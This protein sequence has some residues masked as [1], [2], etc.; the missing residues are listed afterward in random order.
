MWRRIKIYDK[1]L[2]L[3]TSGSAMTQLG[4]NTNALFRS[5]YLLRK[6][7]EEAK[8]Y[9]LSRIEISY[10]ADSLVAEREYFTTDF[11]RMASLDLNNVLLALNYKKGCCYKL[12]ILSLLYA[13][14]DN[15]KAK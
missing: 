14:Q 9:G 2:A 5:S 8:Q 1:G 12:P 11:S 7:L 4:M 13:F 10:Y 15:S 3:L 6:E